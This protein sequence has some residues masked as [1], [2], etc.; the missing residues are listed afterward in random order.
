MAEHGNNLHETRF[1]VIVTSACDRD[2]GNQS[3]IAVS[4]FGPRFG[5]PRARH[6]KAV[7]KILK[8]DRSTNP[9]CVNSSTLIGT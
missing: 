8:R 4:D 7:E 6:A 9:N 1:R 5:F 3:G 2:V